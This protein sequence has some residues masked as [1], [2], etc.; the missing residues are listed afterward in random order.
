M[1][2]GAQ[3]TPQFRA[4]TRTVAVYATVQDRAGALVP[5]LT[6]EHFQILDNGAPVDITTFSKEIVPVTAVL[7]L[8]MSHSMARRYDRV[9]ESAVHLI[10]GLLPA[11]RLRI[12]SFGREVNLSPLLTGNKN[13]LLRV[14]DEELWPGGST[15]IWRASVAAM[16]SLDAESGRRVIILVTDGISR[17][18]ANCTPASTAATG[19]CT[20]SRD[21]SR[22]A[23]QNEF[24]V[25]AIGFSALDPDIR[26]ITTESG[27]G[28]VALAQDADLAAAFRRVLDELHQQYILGFTPAALDGKT[29]KLDVR[30]TKPGLTARAR[31][32]YVAGIE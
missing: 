3:Q 25:Y 19:P 7:L 30:M 24:M 9:R 10:E 2:L 14:I 32:S 12:G 17:D 1:T 18:D 16:D 11:D 4:R 13:V 6:S 29:H 5:D 28:H 27:G 20:T 26:N 21:V 31:R 22:Q 23:L 8:D 15:P